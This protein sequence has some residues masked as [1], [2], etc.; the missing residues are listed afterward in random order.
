MKVIVDSSVF[1]DSLR[2]GRKGDA[3]FDG[4]EKENAEMLIPTV[5]IFELFSGQSTKDPV[6]KKKITA[7]IRNLKRVELTE[8]IAMRAGEL[9]RQFGKRIGVSGHII[10]ASALEIGASIATLNKKHFEQIPHVSLYSGI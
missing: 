2:G 8:E 6:I 7:L 1:I 4:I 9:Y 3:I 5:V 10:A